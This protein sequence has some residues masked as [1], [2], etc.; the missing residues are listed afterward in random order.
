VS[1]Y[2][3]MTAEEAVA[4]WNLMYRREQHTLWLERC[5]DEDDYKSCQFDEFKISMSG[6]HRSLQRRALK[7]N[8]LLR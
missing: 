5:Q 4:I 3:A 2:E 1:Q 8:G 7:A 6:I